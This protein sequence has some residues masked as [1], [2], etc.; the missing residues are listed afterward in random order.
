MRATACAVS[1]EAKRLNVEK[2]LLLGITVLT[3]IN[4][5]S[6]KNELKISSGL[7][8]YVV[9]LAKLA[10]ESGLDGV[11]ASPEEIKVI[12]NACGNDFCILTPG[13]RPSWVTEKD[14]QQRVM[15]PKEAISN[16]ANFIVIGRPIIQNEN[17]VGATIKIIEEIGS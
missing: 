10:K 7:K 5:N 11:V 4:S 12:R 2:P 6:L 16:G 3:S 9:H 13:I 1:D 8:D 17:P 14:D 15:T